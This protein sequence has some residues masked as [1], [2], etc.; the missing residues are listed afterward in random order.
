MPTSISTMPARKLTPVNA[1]LLKIFST[2]YLVC[3]EKTP[4]QW[5]QEELLPFAKDTRDKTAAVYDKAH[6]LKSGKEGQSDIVAWITAKLKQEIMTYMTPMRSPHVPK[7]APPKAPEP[8]FV[9][10][11]MTQVIKLLPNAISRVLGKIVPFFGDIKG[12]VMQLK[13]AVEQAFMYVKSKGLK[14]ISAFPVAGEVI[15]ILRGKVLE[16]SISNAAGGLYATAKLTATIATSGASNLVTSFVDAVMELFKF[17]KSIIDR[18]IMR[19]RFR[20]FALEC[21]IYSKMNLSNKSFEAWF[22]QSMIDI[23]VLAAY[24]V[25]M[26]SFGSPYN[27]LKLIENK[28]RPA[29]KSMRKS[30]SPKAKKPSTSRIGLFFG[31]SAKDEVDSSPSKESDL[32]AYLSLQAEAKTYVAEGI[33][34]KSTSHTAI[35]ELNAARGEANYIPTGDDI[36]SVVTDTLKDEDEEDD[37]LKDALGS[38]EF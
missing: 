25:S 1:E 32:T 27:F 23:P 13:A 33:Q 37:W 5:V 36:H 7:D 12:I 6:D 19:E 10:R 34:I 31:F 24:V 30:Y 4:E 15:D 21:K 20:R 35:K 9:E 18:E 11:I 2:S 16:A 38:I 28:K 8:S 3:D 22:K 29:L 26:P 17:F 14:A